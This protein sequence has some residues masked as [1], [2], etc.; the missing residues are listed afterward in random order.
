[1]LKRSVFLLLLA[2][3]IAWAAPKSDA[4]ESV[5]VEQLTTL[6]AA[7]QAKPD[8]DVAKDLSGLK[9]AERLSPGRFARLNAALPGEK[10]KQAFAILA[11][12]A[13]LLDLPDADIVDNPTP[14]AATLRKMMV[15]IVDYVNTKVHQLPNFVATRET[16]AFEDRPAED[17]P[18]PGGAGTV[19]L[20]YMPIHLV[21]RSSVTVTYRDNRE[22][23]DG[24]VAAK[25]GS[26]PKGLVTAGEFGPFL[27]TVLAD[28]IKGKIT[29]GHWVQGVDGPNA[30][31]HYQV[32]RKQ[33]NYI[34]RFC[35]IA[36]DASES[37]TTHLFSEQAGYHGEIQF[38]PATGAILRLTV[39]A[40]LEP[41]E[42]VSNA[43][44]VVEYLP[45][46]VG[47]RTVTLPARSVSLLQA[48]TARRFDGMTAPTYTGTPKTFLNDTVFSAYHEFRGETRIL[49]CDAKPPQ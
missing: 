9:L 32:P 1:M 30:V 45:I 4:V 38:D 23:M 8:A 14:D 24:K 10:S 40:E 2:P 15:A 35:C 44:M 29:W 25:P 20:S 7:D 37:F 48:H 49:L 27:S 36:E 16:T 18:G 33:S 47:N 39:E 28:A 46:Q 26:Q 17:M 41:G 3:A 13:A 6:L 21:G 19:S 11:D 5:T 34:V 43:G 12:S 22:V 31:F 42:L